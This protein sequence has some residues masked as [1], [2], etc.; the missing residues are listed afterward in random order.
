MAAPRSFDQSDDISWSSASTPGASDLTVDQVSRIAQ[1]QGDLRTVTLE[2][3]AAL[4][5][6]N[7]LRR[8]DKLPVPP[9]RPAALADLP[10]TNRA[11]VL[12]SASPVHQPTSSGPEAT[13]LG[14]LVLLKTPAGSTQ[15]KPFALS[16]GIY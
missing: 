4:S 13:D 10:L 9:D 8:N 15:Q 14:L 2:R 3:D 1:L 12:I 5:E 11:T 16:A 6:L 7:R